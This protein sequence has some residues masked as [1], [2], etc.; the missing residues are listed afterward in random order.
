MFRLNLVCLALCLL[1]ACESKVER[2]GEAMINYPDITQIW[3]ENVVPYQQG[4]YMYKQVITANGYTD[5]SM[6]KASQVDW[7]KYETAF[8][9]SNIYKK[10]LN[11]MYELDFFEDAMSG[12]RTYLFTPLSKKAITKKL[13]VQVR[14]TDNA[15]LSFYAETNDVGFFNSTSYKLLLA[16]GK[17][18]QLQERSKRAFSSP[19]ASVTTLTFLN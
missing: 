12:T 16:T 7:K 19:V 9:A 3:K 18:I 11:R 8:F 15:L 6:L 4:I 17:T 13:S 1:C 10:E 14:P 2:T 5:T